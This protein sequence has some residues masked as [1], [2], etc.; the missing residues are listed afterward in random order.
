[1]KRIFTALIVA[2]AAL[3]TLNTQARTFALVVGISNYG[4]PDLN[5]TQP[6]NDAKAFRDILLTHTKDV[7]LLTSSYATA[8]NIKEKLTAIVNRAQASD[9][10]IFYYSGHGYPGGLY[11]YDSQF[12]Y[13]QLVQLLSTSKAGEVV[14]FI[15]ACHAGTIGGEV[16]DA[17]NWYNGIE[18]VKG[19]AYFLGCR[20]EEYSI[21]AGYYQ[22][23][24]FTVGLLTGYRGKADTNHDRKV[25]IME[26]F[27]HIYKDCVRRS[28]GS[29][30]PV[31]IAPSTMHDTILIE[32]PEE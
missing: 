6:T 21:A 19:H 24:F 10:I 25:T 26:L 15:D 13:D 8:D 22:K 20:P 30:H 12:P 3:C 18:A 5:L 28:D 31:L 14:V 11:C 2:I 4:D 17:S 9:R 27:K 32:Y 29:Q 23:S 7:T 1:M 16:G